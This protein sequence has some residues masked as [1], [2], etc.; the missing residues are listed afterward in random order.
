MATILL[1]VSGSIAAYK[2][3]DLA[4]KLKQAGHD[5]TA[6]LTRSACQLISPHTFLNLTGNRCYTDLWDPAGQTE[7]IALTDRA[8][9]LVLAPATAHLIAR[10]AH[11]LADDMLT[12]TALAVR[13]PVLVVPAMNTRMWD[14][15]AVQRN[16]ALLRELGHR[17]LTPGSG[18]LA[19][20][21]VGPGRLPETPEIMAAVEEA[22]GAPPAPRQLFLEIATYDGPPGP[23][24][25]EQE[26]RF[27]AELVGA[28]ELIA[29]GRLGSP[30]SHRWGH[31]H[32]AES[33]EAA[34]A[35]ARR[36]PLAQHNC[37]IEVFPWKLEL[38]LPG[39]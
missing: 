29:S 33:L 22:L 24:E 10:L 38:G 32:R 28:G 8:D 4:S 27:R 15:P 11:G 19:C 30:G 18:N 2:A 14:H 23:E 20:G 26:K 1:G 16:V 7:H 31:L 6:L 36:S 17:L 37:R 13:C 39:P 12:T 25:V 9:L 5:V 34:M 3:A 21:H 35:R